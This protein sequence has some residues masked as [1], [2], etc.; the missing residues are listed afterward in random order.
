MAGFFAARTRTIP[1]LPWQTFAP[2]FS[3]QHKGR[4]CGGLTSK[5]HAVVEASGLPVRPGLSPGEPWP[6]TSQTEDVINLVARA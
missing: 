2:P 1:P 4:S 6:A 3:E 5:V